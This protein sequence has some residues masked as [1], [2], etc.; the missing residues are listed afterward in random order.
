MSNC[1]LDDSSHRAKLTR[2]VE[3]S[4]RC[5][6]KAYNDHMYI[7]SYNYHLHQFYNQPMVEN[8]FAYISRIG[9]T[10]LHKNDS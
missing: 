6:L 3:M 2:V 1:V 4:G 9:Q 8:R 7:E 5:T 10:N